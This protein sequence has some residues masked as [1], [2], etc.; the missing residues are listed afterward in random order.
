M[1]GRARGKEPLAVPKAPQNARKSQKEGTGAVVF[2]VFTIKPGPH[3]FV[4]GFKALGP[5]PQM[6]LICQ[7]LA[8]ASWLALAQS[9]HLNQDAAAPEVDCGWLALAERTHHVALISSASP[10]EPANN[11]SSWLALAQ[12]TAEVAAA[13]PA[14]GTD[15]MDA[16]DLL[17]LDS[18]AEV[19]AEAEAEA[20]VEVPAAALPGVCS[21][22]V[23]RSLI[24][25]KPNPLVPSVLH[26]TV[27]ALVR[28]ASTAGS[29][30]STCYNKLMEAVQ[31]QDWFTLTLADFA[32]RVDRNR[33]T[34]PVDLQLL[35][36]SLLETDRMLRTCMEEEV[37][38]KKQAKQQEQDL[39]SYVDGSAYDET[40][41][42]LVIADMPDQSQLD[43]IADSLPAVDPAGGDRPASV[44]RV[45]TLPILSTDPYKAPVKLLQSEQ[46]FGLLVRLD[47]PGMAYGIIV[48][49]NVNWIQRISSTSH[50][51]IVGAQE[52]TSSVTKASAEF[53]H[54]ARTNCSDEAKSNPLAERVLLRRRGGRWSSWRYGCEV[55][56]CATAFE[57]TFSLLHDT[58]SGMLNCA[59]SLNFGSNIST[60]RTLVKVN[61][62]ERVRFI[63]QPADPEA[64]AFKMMMMRC[65]LNTGSNKSYKC[66]LLHQLLQGDWRN[67][68]KVEVLVLPGEDPEQKLEMV[69]EG[70]SMALVGG[71]MHEW[72]RHRWRGADISVSQLG[73]LEAAHS[74]LSWV[75]PLFVQSFQRPAATTNNMPDVE[76][77]PGPGPEPSAGSDE[78]RPAAVVA[79]AAAAGSDDPPV[80]EQQPQPRGQDA[81]EA[82]N[83]ASQPFPSSEDNTRFRSKGLRFVQSDVLFQMYTMRL[84]MEPLRELLDR[85][86][87]IGSKRFERHQAATAASATNSS[88]WP[89]REFSVTIAAKNIAED[90]F[91]A[92]LAQV[93]NTSLWSCISNVTVDSQTLV[94]KL[95]SRAGCMVEQLLRDPHKCTQFQCFNVMYD[96]ALGPDIA[97]TDPCLLHPSVEELVE[98]Y[99]SELGNQ[100][101]VHHLYLLSL[102]IRTDISHL[103][104]LHATIRRLLA[105]R[106][107]THGLGMDDT[108]SAW[109]LRRHRSS[110]PETANSSGKR[111][112]E[113]ADGPDVL[114]RPAT[115]KK[116][117]SWNLF[118]RQVRPRPL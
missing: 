68:D 106:N 18:E 99:G 2:F 21:D 26:D 91:F 104:S 82:Q 27:L 69:S 70:V 3:L 55:H 53:K 8:M 24:A 101:S 98:C 22:G 52:K 64:T 43:A 29:A 76:E 115:A 38:A 62:K 116:T 80:P 19:P 79:V 15:D 117:N 108:N 7:M 67:K 5:Y 14:A 50:P 45:P 65:F 37:V 93:S 100:E 83:P 88:D 97:A 84:I 118:C 40:P 1:P 114:K 16:D 32:N 72:P 39:I 77:M 58:V 17:E 9:I 103:E 95:V 41:M 113:D 78:A 87:Y 109:C 102:M 13:A 30:I 73:L 112:R 47:D 20:L 81:G 25:D 105:Q 92:K 48:G 6:K 96:P 54:R 51:C 85:K 11:G 86:L 71:K 23:L 110:L 94:F 34:L 56:K 33:R 42:P 35:A 111:K 4:L 46:K 44:M 63:T 90:A 57:H 28:H 49:E 66:T 36:S 60:F 75:Y 10:G 31:G 12:R 59:L 74:M 61:L 89:C 107:Q